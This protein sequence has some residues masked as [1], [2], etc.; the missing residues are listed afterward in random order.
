MKS[1]IMIRSLLLFTLLV[2]SNL[3]FSGNLF[4]D[5]DPL[6]KTFIKNIRW[7]PDQKFQNSLLYNDAWQEFSSSVGSWSVIFDESNLK[8]RVAFG[9]PV[10][11]PGSDPASVAVSF[12]STKLS[13]FEIPMNDL[14]YV[15]TT[16]A[17]KYHYVNYTQKY[18]GLDV[19]FSFVQVKMN[20]D[21]SV[22]L[23][24]MN[25]YSDINI[26][27]NPILSVTAA[28]AAATN[29]VTNI[30]SVSTD[31]DVKVLPVPEYRKYE[32]HLVY[33][34][35]VK[36]KDAE[37]I[38]AEYYT[39]VNA[40]NGDV[41]Y[42]HNKV[43]HAAN[44]D[45]NVNGTLYPT[46]PYNGTSVEPL[47][48]LKIV[49]GGTTYY[50]DS[51]GYLGLSNTSS[52][53]A[54][55]SLEGRW[56]RIRTNNSTP[57]WTE[58]L[59]P[60]QNTLSADPH[61][62]IKEISAFNSVNVVHNYM[63]SKFPTFT[64]MDNPLNT[65][66]DE[67]GSCNAFYNGSSINF[68]AQ[69]G[70]CNATSLVADVVYHEYG[71]GINDKFYDFIGANWSN[72]AM[73]EGYADIWGL[74]ITGSPV[75]GIGFYQNDPTGFVRRYDVDRKV[76]PQD[77]VGQVHADGEIIAGAWWDTGLNLGNLQQM[78]DIFAETYYAGLTAANGNE[79]I[80]YTDI[81]IE[82]LM[83]DDNDGNLS[84][85]T[86]N[87]CDITSGFAIHG[88]SLT[89]ASGF[90]HSE[91]LSV[92]A[93][94][95][96]VVSATIASLPSGSILRGF[97]DINSSGSWIPFAFTNTTGTSYEGN[98]PA[99]PAGTIISYFLGIED[100]CGTLVN[101]TPPGAGDLDPNIPFYIMVGYNLLHEE[102]FDNFAGTWLEGLPAD[103]ATTGNWVIDIPIPSFVGTGMVQTDNQVTPNGLF[104]AV[105]AN[106]QN[107]NSPAG[108]QDVDD[109]ETTLISPA[110][111]LSTYTAPAISYYRWYSNDQGAT[112]GTDSWQ[113]AV[114]GDGVNW[115]PVENTVV[116]D[117]GWRRFAFRVLDFITPT[118]TVYV[119]FI[120]EDANAGSLIEAA[121]DDLFIWD[122]VTTGIE[123]T[124]LTNF[125]LFPNPATDQFNLNIGL[126]EKENLTISV[127]D[128][129]GRVVQSQFE[130]LNA[131]GHQ[132]S[133]DV[134]SLP[135]GIYQVSLKS[136]N[137]ITSKK[138]SLI[139]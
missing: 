121:I 34:V 128:A 103:N 85:G 71:H 47:T 112:P 10:Y 90:N 68:F 76:Y 33:E 17:P 127:I 16:N 13:S 134:S 119:R 122:E 116:S 7:Q 83:V 25:S 23:F 108:D 40:N 80:L 92:A 1:T 106:A 93:Q 37:G 15:G 42:R 26:N 75:L 58:T 84:N 126:A 27:V 101:V 109:G 57:S 117:H 41:M 133:I 9:A 72:G 19:L 123:E 36:T 31:P 43:S 132:L 99:Q 131:G 97:Y 111:D 29:G 51:I 5:S 45:V 65:N 6:R 24:R 110:F 22:N 39:L 35:T 70:G 53:S 54:T 21:L 50:T 105:T 94:Q 91:M 125:N 79:G 52:V 129:A 113:V 74:G 139:K 82:A 120:A 18:Q 89:T 55:L 69:G 135:A 138:I 77:L 44:T 64:L 96:V 124:S 98:I 88:I 61:A 48:D 4:T 32:Y 12:I 38:P 20:H 60:G 102:D 118:S 56:S 130:S 3:A 67:A 115:T 59:Q 30:Q 11:L 14:V 86:P 107:A 104:C 63:K 62:N 46:N 100:N 66:I 136:N 73:G 95:P 114:S 78:V 28:E 2:Y 81:L 8:P 87:Y 137:F 49:V